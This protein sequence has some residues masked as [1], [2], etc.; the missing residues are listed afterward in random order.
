MLKT[1]SYFVNYQFIENGIKMST[2]RETA[3]VLALDPGTT[4]YGYAVLEF[5]ENRMR[6]LKAGRIHRT[7]RAMNKDLSAQVLGYSQTIQSLIKELN[8]TH[9]IAERYMS[10]RM[11]GVTIE[12]VNSMIGIILEIGRR[13]RISVK[14]IPAS[15]WKNEA[16][17]G[18]EGFLL[19]AYE[20]AKAHKITD[21]TVDASMIAVYGRSIILGRKPFV[22]LNSVSMIENLRRIGITDIGS[23]VKKIRKVRR[24]RRIKK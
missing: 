13:N 23:P 7:I 16:N 24:R 22:G 1:I 17:R 4:N 3:I 6:L 20:M 21:H 5:D 14:L 12:C 15:Q 8:V 19:D 11:G 2:S 9:M 10:R 18:K